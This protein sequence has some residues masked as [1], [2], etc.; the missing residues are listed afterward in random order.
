MNKLK[1]TV[2]VIVIVFALLFLFANIVPIAQFYRPAA[3]DGGFVSYS[4]GVLKYG[5][6]KTFCIQSV[7]QTTSF[8]Q[9]TNYS[10]YLE[11]RYSVRHL[12][13]FES[14][15]NATTRSSEIVLVS[16]FA[17]TASVFLILLIAICCSVQRRLTM[18]AVML[19]MTLSGILV[20]ST[21]IPG[22]DCEPRHVKV[23]F[24]NCSFPQ[25]HVR[26]AQLGYRWEG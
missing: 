20:W 4:N 3:R 19:L 9:T 24:V 22:L 14:Y 6:P 5:W 13:R 1:A 7:T 11:P 16:N 23:I 17:Q 2:I 12:L 8:S 18:R 15:R 21:L 10:R 25:A 26:S